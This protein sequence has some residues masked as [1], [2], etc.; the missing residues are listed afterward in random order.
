MNNLNKTDP[1]VHA[2]QIIKNYIDKH[3]LYKSVLARML[4]ISDSQ[5]NRYQ[6]KESIATAT[7]LSIS[8][9]M[10]HNFFADIAA[11]LPASYSTDAPA[12]TTITD[13]IAALEKENEL[14][15]ERVKVLME[16]RK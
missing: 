3:R 13:R 10:K 7:L 2:G 1:P 9:A 5:V 6:K 11:M 12:D 14:L 4:R 16:M 8:H 15:Q